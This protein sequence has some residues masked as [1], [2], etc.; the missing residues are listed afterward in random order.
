MT[1]MRTL[2]LLIQLLAENKVGYAK[3]LFSSVSGNDMSDSLK[4]TDFWGF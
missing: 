2:P 4:Y 3:T 1:T